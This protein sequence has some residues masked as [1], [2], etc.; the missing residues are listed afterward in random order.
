MQPYL[1]PEVE[2][3]DS[4]VFALACSA[5]EGVGLHRNEKKDQIAQT[6][7]VILGAELD[8]KEGV[9]SAPRDRVVCLSLL[10]CKIAQL[11]SASPE[12]LESI[13][14]SW[15]HILLFRRPLFCILDSLFREGK[16]LGRTEVFTISPQGRNELFLLGIL[17][18]L[19]QADLRAEYHP[20][21]C[22]LDASPFGGA[23]VSTRV[24]ASAAS[25]LWRHAEQRGYYTRLSPAATSVLAELGLDHAGSDMFGAPEVSPLASHTPPKRPWSLSRPIQE[26]YLYDCVELFR[27]S[28]NWSLAH[29]QQGLTIHAGLDSCAGR[30]L[31]ADITSPS[32]ARELIGM[33]ARRII[34]ERH[35][36]VPC[37][38]FGS[39]RR[40][41]VRSRLY[42][43]GFNPTEAFTAKHN[44]IARITACILTV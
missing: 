8:G 13:L 7:G 4:Q 10:T 6:A 23:I 22:A 39:L 12:L 28:G 3:R 29:E 38:S 11:G 41:R 26:G 27:G 35:A 34:R 44:S 33:A 18:G 21:L 1:K 31:R 32:V 25:E 30:G 43:S 42:P 37:V 2:A 24:G 14:G 9:V 17:G 15:I 19:G 5:Y 16:G 20:D 36:G 40:P